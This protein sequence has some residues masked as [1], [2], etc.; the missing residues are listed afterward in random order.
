VWI[1]LVL[2]FHGR[3]ERLNG[4]GLATKQRYGHIFV[5][6]AILLY[7]LSL[8]G[9]DG[10]ILDL[11]GLHCHWK[12]GDGTYVI[13][14]LQG[15]VK[16][17]ANDRDHLLSCVLKTSSGVDVKRSLKHLMD[18]KTTRGLVDGPAIMDLGEGLTQYGICWTL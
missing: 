18:F 1:I 6:Y 9:R 14:T 15:T 7:V 8:W 2:L 11:D 3:D 17:K 13:V 4:P 5:S 12:S 16:G 10:L